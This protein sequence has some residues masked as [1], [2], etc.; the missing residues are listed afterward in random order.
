MNECK[1]MKKKYG[2]LVDSFIKLNCD[3]L[4]DAQESMNLHTLL[5]TF[6]ND[7]TP[8]VQSHLRPEHMV[9]PLSLDAQLKDIIGQ[10]E[11]KD[12]MDEELP[13]PEILLRKF[14]SYD[15]RNFSNERVSQFIDNVDL[16][17]YC[18]RAFTEEDRM[19]ESVKMF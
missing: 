2:G 5:T 14:S 3:S 16:C 17:M 13:S 12:E 6:L 15:P 19:K 11:V 1:G 18:M 8:R 9:K 7:L 10:E 4:E